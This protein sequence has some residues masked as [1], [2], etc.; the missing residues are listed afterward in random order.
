M[1]EA[2]HDEQKDGA[3]A[4]VGMTGF[5]SCQR[6]FVV[7]GEGPYCEMCGGSLPALLDTDRRRYQRKKTYYDS[8]ACI[9][10][11]LHNVMPFLTLTIHIGTWQ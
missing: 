6:N 8:C 3:A 11:C 7:P 10:L 4:A 9:Y 5:Q 1:A 2:E